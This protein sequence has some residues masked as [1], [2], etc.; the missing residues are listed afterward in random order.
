HDGEVGG[1]AAAVVSAAAEVAVHHPADHAR[2][3]D[4][5]GVEHPLQQGHGHHVAVGHVADLVCQ[6]G[7]GLVVV[8]R[9]QQAGGHR[10]Q[11]VVAVGAGCEGVVLGVVVEH[12]LFHDVGVRLFLTSH[13]GH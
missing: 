3:Y 9:A 5:E 4:H 1:T 8:H 6:H 11:R 7:L 2:Q 13:S 10:H 12:H